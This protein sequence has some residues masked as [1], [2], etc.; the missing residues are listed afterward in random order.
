M[1][2]LVITKQFGT[3]TGATISTLK[4]LQSL[5]KEFDMIEVLTLKSNIDAPEYIKLKCVKNVCSLYNTAKSYDKGYIGYSDDHLGFILGLVGI[6][7][8]HTYHGNW[9][10]ARYLSLDFFIKS[11]I[12]IPLYTLTIKNASVVV[13]VSEYMKKKF[14]YRRNSNTRVI[15][16][17]I[18]LSKSKSKIYKENVTSFLM[19]GNIDKRKYGEAIQIFKNLN[20]KDRTIKIDIYGSI[21]DQTVA[22]KLRKNKFVSIKGHRDT[23]NYDNYD[24]LL[25]TSRSENLPVSIVESLKSGTPVIS[26]NV[27]GISEVIN[28]SSGILIEKF[29]E[30]NYLKTIVNVIKYNKRIKVSR[31]QYSKFDWDYAAKEYLSEFTSML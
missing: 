4:L 15:Y 7:Y 24:Y 29:D 26:F 11:L 5:S 30:Y 22:K 3:Y 23:I 9:P 2:L 27:G 8:L 14:V 12:L 17:G 16:N 6:K 28:E 19:V 21:V 10:D 25:N 13:S 1:K 31:D 20:V 18:M